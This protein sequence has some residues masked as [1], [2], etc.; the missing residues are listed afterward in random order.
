MNLQKGHSGGGGMAASPMI[1]SA[2]ST[3]KE[4]RI[5]VVRIAYL[6]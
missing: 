1:K 2:K 4:K 5:G 3:E 6:S